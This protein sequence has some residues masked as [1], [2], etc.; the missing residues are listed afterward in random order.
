MVDDIYCQLRFRLLLVINRVEH[1]KIKCNGLPYIAVV[2]GGN[3]CFGN[4]L[5]LNNGL[6]YNPIGYP[7][8]CC[9]VVSSGAKLIIG[10]NVGMSQASIICHHSITIGD[11]VKIGGGVKIYDTNFHSLD[12]IVR[13]NH[14]Q[15]MA[16]KKKEP[17]IIEHDVFIGAGS[18][19]LPGVTIGANS[20]V[21]AG[22]VVTKNIPSNQIWGGNPAKLLRVLHDE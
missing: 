21:G 15:D 3:C 10:N 19:I 17:V 18:I 14:E 4:N 20:V 9:I 11:N 22:S 6:R 7:Q 12:P 13:R 2:S 16:N 5:T 1:E 8:P